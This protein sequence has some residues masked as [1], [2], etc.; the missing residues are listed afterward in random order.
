MASP[1]ALKPHK[2]DTELQERV[3]RLESILF[4]SQPKAQGFQSGGFTGMVPNVGQP[5]T[6][7]HYY[8]DVEPGSYILNRNAVAGMKGYQ[9]G[10]TVPVALEKGEIAMPPGSYDQK[11]MDYLNYEAFPRFQKGGDVP[12]R[13]GNG[14][15]VRTKSNLREE[16]SGEARVPEGW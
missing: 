1:P 14:A 10:G 11:I 12:K 8:T 4:D 5:T 13:P 9:S 7:D 6:G 2:P 3:G 16:C 15:L